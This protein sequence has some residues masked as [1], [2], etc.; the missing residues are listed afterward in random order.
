[1]MRSIAK[2]AILHSFVAIAFCAAMIAIAA[3]PAA[4]KCPPGTLL[5]VIHRNIDTGKL[6]PGSGS[7]LCL[8]A[9]KTAHLVADASLSAPKGTYTFLFW[10]VY[11]KLHT[12]PGVSVKTSKG[13]PAFNATAWYLFN[14]ACLAPPC[15]GGSPN[16]RT[17]G[18]EVDTNKRLPGT[19]IA[20]VT[21]STNAWKSP[22]TVVYTNTAVTITAKNPL[23]FIYWK[24][25]P[26]NPAVTTKS[27]VLSAPLNAE[28]LLAIAFYGPNP[29]PQISPPG[30]GELGPGAGPGAYQAAA[31]YDAE[32][33][34]EC[35]ARHGGPA[36]PAP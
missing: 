6:A 30:P 2:A 21:P 10:D 7:T 1:M 31:K 23:D 22:Q 8:E 11:G 17:L 29:C 19:P 15:G 27:T 32:L 20:S 36:A 3:A 33:Y 9:G 35:V 26:P 24:I 28:V 14:A 5:T 34:A 16:V 4:A 25:F 12:T 13:E 18:F